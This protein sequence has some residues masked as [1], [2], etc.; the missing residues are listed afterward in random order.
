MKEA[1]EA[2][3]RFEGKERVRTTISQDEEIAG[4]DEFGVL[5]VTPGGEY[6]WE[7]RERRSKAAEIVWC[8]PAEA[9]GFFCDFI[10][11]DNV[12]RLMNEVG[13]RRD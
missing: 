4:D 10:A 2:R 8:S 12:E 3:A 11:C 7:D 6:Y 13:V 9:W 5:K 1:H